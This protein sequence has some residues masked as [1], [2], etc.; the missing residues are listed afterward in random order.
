METGGHDSWTGDAGIKQQD[1]GSESKRAKHLQW[2]KDR[3][4][5]ILE[6]GDLNEA[7]MSMASDLSGEPETA[8]ACRILQSLGLPLLVGGHLDTPQRMREFILG[9]N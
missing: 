4:I 1:P 5:E 7:F 6:S 3:A 2:C 9:F 8:D